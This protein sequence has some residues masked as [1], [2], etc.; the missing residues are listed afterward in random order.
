MK[1]QPMSAHRSLESVAVSLR[2]AAPPLGRANPL[3]VTRACARIAGVRSDPVISRLSHLVRPLAR[4]AAG[5]VL[6]SGVT[7]LLRPNHRD[8]PPAGLPLLDPLPF[9]AYL[10]TLV[11]T[12]GVTGALAD[13]SDNLLSDLTVLTRVLNDRSQAILF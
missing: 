7:V 2:R 4:I 11:D 6:L 3:R 9:I 10:D 13:E 1:T 5:L 12:C 8:A